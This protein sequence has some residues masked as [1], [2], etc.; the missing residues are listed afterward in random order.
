VAVEM[1]MRPH[2][3]NLLSVSGRAD[4]TEITAIGRGSFCMCLRYVL[5]L[6]QW[7]N[8]GACLSYLVSIDFHV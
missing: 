3:V 5:A 8:I 7:I 4:A 1:I 6:R 2:F